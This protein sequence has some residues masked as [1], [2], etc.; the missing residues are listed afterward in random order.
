[1]EY[2]ETDYHGNVLGRGTYIYLVPKVIANTEKDMVL[3][4]YT[5]EWGNV[6]M[7]NET[8]NTFKSKELADEYMDS[9]REPTLE[10]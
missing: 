4:P 2:I 9:L 6:S 1:M 3:G 10:F 5:N 7:L 8:Y